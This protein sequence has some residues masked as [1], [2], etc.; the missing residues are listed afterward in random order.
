MHYVYILYSKKIERYYTGMTSQIEKR[1]ESHNTGKSVYTKKGIPWELKWQSEGI[2]K[3]EAMELEKRIKKR[4]ASRF[5][6]DM[7]T[8]S[9]G[10]AWA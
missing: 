2:A 3:K 4:G 9:G 1:I 10:H 7:R 6:S 8:K 5:I